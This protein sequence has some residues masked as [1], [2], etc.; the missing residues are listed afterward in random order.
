MTCVYNFD[1]MVIPNVSGVALTRIER[2]LRVPLVETALRAVRYP[3][4]SDER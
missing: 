2:R 4:S 3:L 1:R